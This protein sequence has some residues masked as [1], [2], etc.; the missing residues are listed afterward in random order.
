MIVR[1][2]PRAIGDIIVIA[3]YIKV[4]IPHAAVRV[5]NAITMSVDHE[6]IV[7]VHI[8]D[9]RRRPLRASDL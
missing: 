1:Y 4:R 5:E 2:A 9:D 6:A 8:R 7:I 3:D